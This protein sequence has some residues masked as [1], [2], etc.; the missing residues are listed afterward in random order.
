MRQGDTPPLICLGAS[1]RPYQI[2]PR[3]VWSIASIQLR[4]RI[5]L[6]GERDSADASDK[7]TELTHASA[8]K[9]LVIDLYHLPVVTGRHCNAVASVPT[10]GRRKSAPKPS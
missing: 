4:A 5:N 3:V 10:F 2:A 6:C 9:Y 8:H 7:E 1:I